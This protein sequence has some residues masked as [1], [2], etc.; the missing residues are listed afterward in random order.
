MEKSNMPF[1]S[2]LLALLLCLSFL[3]C[4]SSTA[5]EDDYI[6]ENWNSMNGKIWYII[7][8]SGTALERWKFYT[9]SL[10]CDIDHFKKYSKD[11]CVV[12][13]RER[14]KAKVYTKDDVQDYIVGGELRRYKV[15]ELQW[16]RMTPSLTNPLIWTAV[17]DWSEYQWWLIERISEH[18]ACV[19]DA[20][21]CYELQ[22]EKPVRL[23]YGGGWIY[24]EL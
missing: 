24:D 16:K 5:Q 19:G 8:S 14:M 13:Y 4:S 1:M 18:T 7:Q 23:I 2:L 11:S 3:S 6:G 22:D 9:D 12:T 10:V 15:S 17:Y 20:P 21:N